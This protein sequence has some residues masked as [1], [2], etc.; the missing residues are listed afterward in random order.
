MVVVHEG[1]AKGGGA[2]AV[3]RCC[4]RRAVHAARVVEA[5]VLVGVA[6]EI[7]H[8]GGHL[9]GAVVVLV[10]ALVVRGGGGSVGG[11]LRATKTG[12]RVAM[13]QLDGGNAAQR[14]LR[15]GARVLHVAEQI[16]QVEIVHVRRH[17]GGVGL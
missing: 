7:E 17:G 3:R 15:A 2:V 12:Q 9:C 6:E 1:E 13:A 11:V 5:V 16:A 14:V 10:V 8:G 4:E